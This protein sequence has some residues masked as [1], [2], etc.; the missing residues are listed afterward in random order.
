MMNDIIEPP[1]DKYTDRFRIVY[2]LLQEHLFNLP[3]I[4]ELK[5]APLHD[6]VKPVYEQ[7]K[8]RFAYRNMIVYYKELK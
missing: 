6:A 1:L 5:F 8:W 3:S 7:G 2:S 4:H